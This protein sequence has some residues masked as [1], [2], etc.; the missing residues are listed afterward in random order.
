VADVVA[1]LV[2]A[3]VVAVVTDAVTAVG[4]VDRIDEESGVIS[5]VEPLNLDQFGRHSRDLGNTV[6]QNIFSS[7]LEK[8]QSI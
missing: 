8:N 1:V 2:T 4:A 6:H 7:V 3:A 5:V